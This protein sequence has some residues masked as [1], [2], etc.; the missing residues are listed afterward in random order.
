MHFVH[1]IRTTKLVSWPSA[2]DLCR[3][4]NRRRRV[5]PISL[6]CS[7]KIGPRGSIERS[8]AEHRAHEYVQKQN[9]CHKVE[10]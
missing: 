9:P 10:M 6:H 2:Y 1:H 8:N 7:H 5:I 3:S 4:S